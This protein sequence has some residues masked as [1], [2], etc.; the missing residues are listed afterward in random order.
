MRNA[1]GVMSYQDQIADEER[2]HRSAQNQQE[3]SHLRCQSKRAAVRYQWPYFFSPASMR[4]AS[5]FS[6]GGKGQVA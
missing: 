6:G 3:Y 4:T 1:A 5:R 2:T